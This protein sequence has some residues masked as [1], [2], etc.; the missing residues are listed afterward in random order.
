MARRYW[1]RSEYGRDDAVDFYLILQLVGSSSEGQVYRRIGI[2]EKP[3]PVWAWSSP[4]RWRERVNTHHA[5]TAT[6]TII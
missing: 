5:E 6:V 1:V 3:V 2:A 4:R